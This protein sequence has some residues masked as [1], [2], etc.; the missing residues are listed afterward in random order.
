LWGGLGWGFMADFK[1]AIIPILASEGYRT[2]IS[3]GYVNDPDDRGKETVAGISRYF[4]PKAKIWPLIDAAK[5]KPNFPESLVNN[6]ELFAL[7]LEFYKLN[8]WDVVQ[9]DKIKNQDIGK[10]I[11]DTAVLEGLKP[12]IKRAEEIV[13]IKLTGIMSPQL[14]QL[15]NILL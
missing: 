3:I 1:K 8:F 12:A 7:I 6:E 2:S 15:L 10:I 9:S 11:V 14:L 5:L 13:G 4:W